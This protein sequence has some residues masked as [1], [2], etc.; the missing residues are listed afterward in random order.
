[1]PVANR[2]MP[3]SDF[4]VDAVFIDNMLAVEA[5]AHTRIYKKVSHDGDKAERK[6]IK[7]AFEPLFTLCAMQMQTWEQSVQADFDIAGAFYSGRINWQQKKAVQQMVHALKCGEEFA[8]E[9]VP[10]FMEM[11]QQ[12][13]RKRVSD[14]ALEEKRITWGSSTCPA[15]DLQQRVTEKEL[16]T[17][18]WG[19]VKKFGHLSAQ[20]GTVEYPQFPEPEQITFSNVTTY[21]K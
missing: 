13:Y 18:L 4:S 11:A 17:S 20:S 16:C 6:R 21:A 7:A 3:D 12:A 5:S 10:L 14:R 9:D 2:S 1:M 19:Y 15:T 8:P